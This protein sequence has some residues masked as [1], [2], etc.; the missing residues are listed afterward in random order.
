M[1]SQCVLEALYVQS[2]GSTGVLIEEAGSGLP[3]AS[4]SLARSFALI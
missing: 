3:P 2:Q 4:I 1:R